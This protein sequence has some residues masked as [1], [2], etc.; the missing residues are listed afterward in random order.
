MKK[1]TTIK[2]AVFTKRGAICIVAKNGWDFYLGIFNRR[3]EAYQA[4]KETEDAEYIGKVK[5]TSL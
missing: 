5:I 2:W 4:F 3:S 1:K